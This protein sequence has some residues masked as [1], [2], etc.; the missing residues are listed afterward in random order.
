MT[1]SKTKEETPLWVLILVLLLCNTAKAIGFV[2]VVLL[3]AW[4]FLNTFA[5]LEPMQAFALN[6]AVLAAMI[7]CK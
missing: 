1:E 3:F 2:L 6:Y 7:I 4:A 5:Q